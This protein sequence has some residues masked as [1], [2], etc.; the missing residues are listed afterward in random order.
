MDCEESSDD[1]RLLVRSKSKKKAAARCVLDS[2]S[3]ESEAE[4]AA[5]A[6]HADG[7]DDVADADSPVV[8]RKPRSR[9]V[10]LQ[11]DTESSSSSENDQADESADDVQALTKGLSDL[12]PFKVSHALTA[13]LHSNFACD[14]SA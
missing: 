8:Q 11:S 13:A 14:A 6:R 9:K 10:V 2:S 1:E 7:A 5:Q 12:K 3:S 4:S